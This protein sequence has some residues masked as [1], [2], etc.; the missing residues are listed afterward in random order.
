MLAGVNLL[1]PLTVPRARRFSSGGEEED[2]DR[3]MHKVNQ[4]HHGRNTW[5]L[6]FHLQVTETKF[7]LTLEEMHS[8]LYLTGESDGKM[9]FSYDYTPAAQKE[10][11]LRKI[12]FFFS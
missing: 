6:I 9:S 2:F 1:C 8:E 12:N 3:S 7:K 4:L 10:S 11:T 5:V